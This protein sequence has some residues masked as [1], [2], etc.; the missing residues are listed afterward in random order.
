MIIMD[1]PKLYMIPGAGTDWRMYTPQLQAFPDMV[2]PPWLPPLNLYEPLASYARRLALRMDVSQPFFL[3]GVSLGGMLA[4]EMANQVKP[5]GLILISTCQSSAFLPMYWRLLGRLN[6]RLPDG[7]MRVQKHML[8]MVAKRLPIADA[9]ERDIYAQMILDM[10][11]HLVRW[12]VGAA[13]QW[14]PDQK[15]AMPVFQLHGGKDRMMPAARVHAQQWLPDAGHFM[16]VT[17]AGQVNAFIRDC[18]QGY[19]VHGS[20]YYSD[21]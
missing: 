17:H 15:P 6:R 20:P 5:L 11:P 13:T 8:A 4:Q 9:A 3:G 19:S 18:L 16:N 14:K 12:Q 7:M 21:A 1:T 10:P 2:I